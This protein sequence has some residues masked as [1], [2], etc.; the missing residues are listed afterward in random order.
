M[1]RNK[2]N[3]NIDNTNI[4]LYNNN[5]DY[6]NKD[7]ITT[8]TTTLNNKYKIINT[9]IVDNKPSIFV[10]YCKTMIKDFQGLFD[11]EEKNII[12][13][14]DISIKD[15]VFI[16]I[17]NHIKQYNILSNEILNSNE[18]N[19]SKSVYMF[20]LKTNNNNLVLTNKV[21]LNLEVSEESINSLTNKIWYVV[22][23]LSDSDNKY[24]NA[25]RKNIPYK[26][27]NNDVI[28]LGRVKYCVNEIH[29][30][31]K[32]DKLQ[33]IN[34]SNCNSDNDNDSKNT[35]VLNNY[36]L[37]KEDVPIF[38]VIH[39]SFLPEGNYECRYCYINLND[40]KNPLVS[41]CKCKGGS[42]FIHFLC[43]KQWMSTKLEKIVNKSNTVKC[44][45]FKC[46]NCEICKYPYPCKQNKTNK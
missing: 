32:S 4:I 26:V 25:T 42:T 14:F 16:R 34:N 46:F 37:I 2:I 21:D 38:N 33:F 41:L 30:N 15:S 35:F 20:E 12:K 36:E 17:N 43:V 5:K 9:N 45:N 7:N 27:K 1:D 8:T 19:T 40:E 29:N 28:K 44:Y 13:S 22:P 10:M 23:S 31:S 18:L 6:N 24:L 39:K 11:Y 3:C